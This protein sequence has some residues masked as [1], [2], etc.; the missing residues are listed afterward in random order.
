MD[1]TQTRTW[2]RALAAYKPNLTFNILKISYS[3]NLPQIYQSLSLKTSKASKRVKMWGLV[4]ADAQPPSPTKNLDM[5]LSIRNK[6]WRIQ[7]GCRIMPWYFTLNLQK[8]TAYL[9]N[10]VRRFDFMHW[11]II[12]ILILKIYSWYNF[13]VIFKIIKFTCN[14]QY[15]VIYK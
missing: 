10:C 5:Y 12:H 7:G 3:L 1:L 4:V 15:Q 11:Q 13:D 9:W 8:K 6:H 14:I 2:S